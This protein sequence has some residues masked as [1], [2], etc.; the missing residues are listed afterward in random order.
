M[1][2]IVTKNAPGQ[3][4]VV[5]YFAVSSFS[6]I[7]F[8][9]IFFIITDQF[10]YHHTQPKVIAL[11]HTATLL[12]LSTMTMGTLHQFIPVVFK[13]YLYSWKL[14]FFNLF[15]FLFSAAY[16]IIAFYYHRFL[17][18]LP[19]AASLTALSFWIFIFNIL[20]T[21]R[22][23]QQNDIASIFIL[24]SLFWLFITTIYGLLQAF[25]FRYSYLDDPSLYLKLHAHFGLAGWFLLLVIGISSV[26]IPMF[27]ISHRHTD[28][29]L[30]RYS[31]YLIN[32]GIFIMWINW[33]LIKGQR[34]FTFFSWLMVAGGMFFYLKY[35]YQAFKYKKK[36]TDIMVLHTALA[37]IMI[38][39]PLIA[40]G[41][42]PALGDNADAVILKKAIY[43]YGFG[44]I[45]AFYGNLVMGI[46]YRTLPF[47]VWL[48]KYKKFL[49][50]KK[51]PKPDDLYNYKLGL[52]QFY[53]FAIML[54]FLIAGLLT[55]NT[56]IL[57][58]AALLL[59]TASVFYNINVF[60]VIFK[61]KK[62]IEPE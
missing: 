8:S 14:A 24:T 52:V 6:Y 50:K 62:I 34:I 5:P 17:T 42:I 57:K 12:I 38:F 35:I 26:L 20:M 56:I 22:K 39:I 44:T 30:L 23:R 59:L 11:T 49:G 7:V 46:S 29:K 45:I 1:I 47:I 13:S 61:S 2:G 58:G 3:R 16:L 43:L 10:A 19:V 27:F 40:G 48:I 28:K 60:A 36:K 54:V 9:I 4:S 21:Y 53:T 18:H 25:N 33:Q 37:Y 31:Y 51:V 15:L 55:Q 32:A 41:L